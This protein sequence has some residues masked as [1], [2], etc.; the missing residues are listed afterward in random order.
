M[1]CVMKVLTYI[2]MYIYIYNIITCISICY[3]YMRYVIYLLLFFIYFIFYIILIF[4]VFFYLFILYFFHPS[5]HTMQTP[6][7][8]FIIVRFCVFSFFF[9]RHTHTCT[10]NTQ[11]TKQGLLVAK[12][13]DNKLIHAS[14]NVD[15]MNASSELIFEAV[16]HDGQL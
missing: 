3:L 12:T 14:D 6:S 11:N 1:L 13:K 7:F 9:I 10:Y 4:G 8:F 2:Y 15:E 5:S 16:Q